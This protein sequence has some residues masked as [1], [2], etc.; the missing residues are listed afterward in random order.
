MTLSVAPGKTTRVSTRA[1]HDSGG[2]RAGDHARHRAR[3]S[4]RGGTSVSSGWLVGWVSTLMAV[5][6]SQ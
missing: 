5:S 1:V 2:Q 4:A 6:L 3:G